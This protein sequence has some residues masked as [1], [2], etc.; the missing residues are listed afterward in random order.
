MPVE[1]LALIVGVATATATATVTA[2]GD[3]FEGFSDPNPAAEPLPAPGVDPVW[4]EPRQ[5]PVP[6]WVA[7]AFLD[8]AYIFN[9]N[10]PGNHLWPGQVTHPRTGEVTLAVAAGY[11]RHQATS[12]QPWRFELAFHAGAAVDALYAAEPIPGGNA[13][14]YAGPEVWKHVALANGGYRFVSGT[15]IQ[16]GLMAAPIGVGG[17]W[18]KDNWTYSPALASNAVPYY[19]MGGR[20]IQPIGDEVEVDA[21]VVNGWQTIA[22]VNRAPSGLVGLQWARREITLRGQV[23]FGPERPDPAADQW[24]VHGDTQ[25]IWDGHPVGVAAVADVGREG[26]SGGSGDLYWLGGGVWIRGDL[27]QGR[28]AS[29]VLAGRPEAWWDRDGRIYGISQVLLA[30]TVGP[31]L[32]VRDLLQVRLEYRYDRSLGSDGY[33][34]RGDALALAADQH[35]VLLNLLAKFEHAFARRAPP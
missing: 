27:W 10:M 12:E 31:S 14:D 9:H 15:E 3:D 4:A 34:Y 29:L 35:S 8:T 30:G 26:W 28:H 2:P 16:V 24:M 25:V 6:H 13:G 32:Y 1:L 22:D 20:V 21:W 7:G 18:S 23:F 11:L 33:F 19:L 5:L 17:F